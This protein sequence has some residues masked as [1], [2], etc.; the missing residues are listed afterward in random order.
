[1]TVPLQIT[2]KDMEPSP[3][4]EARIRAKAAELERFEHDILRCHV[5][6]EAPHRHHHQGRLYRARVEVFVPRGDV[7]VTRE[8]PLN[9][10]HEDPYVAVRD[11]FDAAIRQLEDHVRKLRRQVKQHGPA[12][13]RGRVA[14]FIAGEDYG[15]IET[16]DG[17]EVYFHRNSVSGNAFDELRV[18]DPV[19]LSV[20]EG[21]KGPQAVV[22]HPV[23][24]HRSAG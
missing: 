5:I 9:H 17:E 8:G 6:V 18:G 13:R 1:M 22:V 12:M 15:F 20:E 23:H 19:H 14:R 21:E 11:A 2:F 7:F 24:R 16:E 4:L 3:A 10:A